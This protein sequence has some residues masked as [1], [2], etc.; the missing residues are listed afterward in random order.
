[1][2][3]FL[4]YMKRVHPGQPEPE[5]M[6][7]EFDSRLDMLHYAA[8]NHITQRGIR[9]Y[10]VIEGGTILFGGETQTGVGDIYEAIER[11]KEIQAKEVLSVKE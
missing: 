1:M 8:E 10:L 11:E 5:L 2:K 7:K 4:I 6:I 3:Y 9:Q